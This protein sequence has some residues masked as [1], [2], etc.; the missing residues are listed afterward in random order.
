[1]KVCFEKKNVQAGAGT[2]NFQENEEFEAKE[3]SIITGNQV[4]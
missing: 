3:S 1:M 4:A 2:Q